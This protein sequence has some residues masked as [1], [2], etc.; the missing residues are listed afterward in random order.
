MLP[1]YNK[2]HA[3]IGEFLFFMHPLKQKFPFCWNQSF[4]IQRIAEDFDLQYISNSIWWTCIS[5]FLYI[6]N[7]QCSLGYCK[8]VQ[9]ISD[10]SGYGLWPR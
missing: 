10:L 8:E 3:E 2:F 9:L 7:Q 4:S 5:T 6:G 1:Q